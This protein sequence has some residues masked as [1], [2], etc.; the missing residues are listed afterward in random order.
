MN[1]ITI[2]ICTYKRKFLF[3]TIKSVLRSIQHANINVEILI[4]D[5]D[6]AKSSLRIVSEFHDSELYRFH[7]LVEPKKGVVNARN[8]ALYST[9][10]DWLIFIDDD[11]TVETDWLFHY[12]ELIS[13]N[14]D[15][16]AAV[17]PVITLYPEYVD[18]VISSSK[19]LDRK[20]FVHLQ[21]IDH[22]ATNNAI[23]N[24]NKLERLNIDF[25]LRFNFLGGE[26]SDFFYRLSMYGTILWNDRSI[27]YEP[28]SIERSSKEWVLNRL[29][30]NG[31]IYG[32]RKAMRIGQYYKLYLFPSSLAKLFSHAFNFMYYFFLNDK[33]NV[34]KFKCE[35]NRDLGRLAS[36]FMVL[37]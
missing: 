10:T 35:I 29:F 13:S 32:L 1:S 15:I 16:I 18:S 8:K 33:A 17:S 2:A 11:E 37:K 36:C 24:M 34:F 7:Y 6:S 4:I 3:N 14:P 27:V 30:I 26:D 25:D 12:K 22:G 9:K 20:R 28:L 23:I 21:K 5:N 31:K 19:V